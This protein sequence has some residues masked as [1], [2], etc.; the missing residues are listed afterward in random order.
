MLPRREEVPVLLHDEAVVT[1]ATQ[2]HGV[3][4]RE[5]IGELDMRI[6]INGVG[7]IRTRALPAVDIPETAD[8]APRGRVL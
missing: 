8:D 1:V 6:V 2:P 4:A 7:E 5:A 3:I